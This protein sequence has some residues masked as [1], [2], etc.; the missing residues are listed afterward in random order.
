MRCMS[1]KFGVGSSSRFHFNVQTHRH[2]QSYSWDINLRKYGVIAWWK[3]TR[4]AD[5]IHYAKLNTGHFWS[6]HVVK[7][8]N[9]K[10]EKY[11]VKVIYN[12]LS[13]WAE[14]HA[15]RWRM[16]PKSPK[17]HY[18]RATFSAKSFN[19]QQRN[20]SREQTRAYWSLWVTEKRGN[21]FLLHWLLHFRQSYMRA[22]RV[23]C[24][25]GD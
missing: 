21:S 22:N 1:T 5:Q 14:L 10:I 6:G 20:K 12:D 17:W 18:E 3:Y 13:F 11:D 2:T 16:Q 15:S 9:R 7:K 25:I 19:I 4:C 24:L 23:H 8:T